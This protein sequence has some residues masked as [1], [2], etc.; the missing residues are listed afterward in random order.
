MGE[1]KRRGTQEERVKAAV[2]KRF[3]EQQSLNEH[4]NQLRAQHESR[5]AL[6]KL[7]MNNQRTLHEAAERLRTAGVGEVILEEKN[8]VFVID[9]TGGPGENITADEPTPILTDVVEEEAVFFEPIEHVTE[10]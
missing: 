10:S 1:A 3:S 5:G 4:L 7:Q 9:A 2:E 8:G 6:Q